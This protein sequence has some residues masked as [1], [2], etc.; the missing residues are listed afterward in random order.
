MVLEFAADF[1]V[2]S[3]GG[4]GEFGGGTGVEFHVETHGQGGGVEGRAEVGRGG[5]KGEV[6]SAF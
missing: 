2:A 6:E 5:G 3:G 1:A 4:D